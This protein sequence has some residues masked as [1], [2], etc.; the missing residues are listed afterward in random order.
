VDLGLTGLV[1]L[2]TGGGSGIGRACAA[3]L[4]AE[5][6]RVVVVDRSRE[7]AE[8]V[9]REIGPSGHAVTAD[10]TDKGQASAMAAA[11]VDRFGGLDLAINSAGVGNGGWARLGETA[12]ESWEA[13]LRVNL[14][15]TFYSIRAEVGAMASRSGA[16]VN[17]ASTMAL[18]SHPGLSAY[19]A[20]KHGVLAL[21]R[22][23]ALDYADEGIRVNAV[24]P[25]TVD[26]PMV[27]YRRE[28]FPA[29]AEGIPLGRLARPQEVATV[30]VLLASPSA[31]FVTGAAWAVDGGY[32]AR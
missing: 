23:A 19:S 25:G 4:A 28:D 13:V 10:I 1:A 3:L 14:T 7:A 8:R 9:A 18:V 27:A 30:A 16:I 11:A 5:G 24:C 21:T 22:V 17:I 26:T 29:I 15:G 32:T 20:S 6:A 31:G 12:P 2:V